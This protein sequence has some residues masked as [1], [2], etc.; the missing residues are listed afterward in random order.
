MKI[1]DITKIHDNHTTATWIEYLLSVTELMILY[2]DTHHKNN[3]Y[4]S[5]SGRRK[6][7]QFISGKITITFPHQTHL[8][9]CK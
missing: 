6:T 7:T 9:Q 5:Y 3:M 4:G 2:G 1:C 8:Q